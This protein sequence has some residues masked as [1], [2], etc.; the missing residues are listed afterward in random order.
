MKREHGIDREKLE[1][2]RRF[3][4]VE[5]LELEIEKIIFGGDGLGRWEGLPVFV[6]R[7]APGDRVRV[8]V[9]ER[10]PGYARAEV[11][12]LL[13]PGE[14]RREPPCPYFERCGGCDLQHLE[15]DAQLRAKAESV[16]E[17]LR[18]L[19]RVETPPEFD[20]VSGDAWGYRMRT[21]LHVGDTERGKAVGYYER[22]SNEL[23]AIESCPILV[24]ELEEILPRLA[25][26]LRDDPHRRLDLAA[27]DEARLTASPPVPALPQGPIEATVDTPEGEFTYVFDA[28]T[29]F[30][31]HR[32]LTPEL[33]ARALGEH[34]DPE[35]TVYDLYSGVGLFTLPLSR[36][37]ARVVAVDSDPT[38]SRYLKKNL[39]AAGASNVETE[40]VSVEHWI[41]KLP[42]GA[43]RVLVDPPRTGLARKIRDVLLER[44][45]ERI[46]YVSC[47]ASTMARDLKRLLLGYEME[48]LVLLDMFPQTGHM[49]QVAQL[50][51]KPPGEAAWEKAAEGETEDES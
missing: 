21:Q 4:E 22:G 15:D 11:I 5:E 10:K 42:E 35:G 36:R 40:Q 24:P 13:E 28:R 6:P 39:R 17:T 8:R 34:G 27:G 33:V 16:V 3:A 31:G 46:T 37:Y 26:K 2:A 23:V 29:F 41:G 14:G 50:V 43:A 9:T 32:Q 7:T 1:R 45:P 25:L 18:R 20:V 30:Q 19:G 38:G 51:R 49:E 44:R 12:E 48:S 47:N